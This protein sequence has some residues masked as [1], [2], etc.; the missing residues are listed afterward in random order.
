MLLEFCIKSSARR[1]SSNHLRCTYISLLGLKLADSASE[2][3]K[4]ALLSTTMQMS[5]PIL[6]GR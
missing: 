6:V 5:E 4:Q 1:K 3:L 2:V